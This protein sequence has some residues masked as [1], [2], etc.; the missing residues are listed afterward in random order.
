V[1]GGRERQAAVGHDVARGGPVFGQAVRTPARVESARLGPT[2]WGGCR[3]GRAAHLVAVRPG[4]V[5]EPPYPSVS[6]P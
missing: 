5:I 4:R 1:R 3:S 6:P 2:S